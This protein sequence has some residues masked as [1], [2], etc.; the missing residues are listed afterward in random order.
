MGEIV[1]HRLPA[2]YKLRN[3]GRHSPVPG[4]QIAIGMTPFE[5]V[6]S[7]SEQISLHEI[8]RQV[9]PTRAGR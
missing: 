2:A 8:P 9:I 3:D 5:C 4:S 6:E 1:D 7:N